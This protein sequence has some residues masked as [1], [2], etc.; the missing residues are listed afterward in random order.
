MSIFL[1][2]WY[3]TRFKKARNFGSVARRFSRKGRRC[4]S[5]R[6]VHAASSL[7]LCR[8]LLD[9]IDDENRHRMLLHFQFQAELLVNR[10]EEAQAS[11][12]I[13]RGSVEYIAGTEAKR[14]IPTAFEP[15]DI[16]DRP[17]DISP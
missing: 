16:H 3:P 4:T 2:A 5:A 12:R 7:V 1:A 6:T 15:G 11:I 10:L 17:I 14:E 13:V 8:L 9:L